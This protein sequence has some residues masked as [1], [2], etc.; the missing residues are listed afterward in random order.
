MT[1]Y[2]HAYVYIYVYIV[3]MRVYICTTEPNTVFSC[4]C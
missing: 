1:I 4:A 2:I 3:D